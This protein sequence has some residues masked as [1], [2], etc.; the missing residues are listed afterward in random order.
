LK[1]HWNDKHDTGIYSFE[2]LRDI[3]S[4]EACTGSRES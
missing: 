3:C 1:F 2:F 4:C